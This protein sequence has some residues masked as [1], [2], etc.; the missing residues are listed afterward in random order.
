M[1]TS[2]AGSFYMM[3][4][5]GFLNGRSGLQ[6]TKIARHLKNQAITGT[7]SLLSYSIGQKSH[8]TAK[9]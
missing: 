1:V 9:I 6:K 2:I 3:S 7:E 5:A 4:P 8:K